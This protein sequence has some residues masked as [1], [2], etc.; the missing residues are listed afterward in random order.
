[1]IPDWFHNLIITG[2]QKL[3]L[4]RLAGTPPADVFDLTVAAWSEALW[5]RGQWDEALDRY[6]MERAFTSLLRTCERWPSP[7]PYLDHL[8]ARPPQPQL[9]PPPL[10]P[11]QRA[12]NGARLRAMLQDLNLTLESRYGRQKETRQ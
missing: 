8:R 11:E 10:S 7:K 6:R 4:L 5:T 9:P 12:R 1:V 3:V 2:L